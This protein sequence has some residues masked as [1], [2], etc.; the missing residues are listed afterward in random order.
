[1]VCLIRGSDDEG[2]DVCGGGGVGAGGGRGRHLAPSLWQEDG[3]RYFP[4][5]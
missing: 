1:M 4:Q 3:H 5:H 2:G